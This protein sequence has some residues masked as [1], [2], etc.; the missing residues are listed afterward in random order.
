MEFESFASKMMKERQ[1]VFRAIFR[2]LD[3]GGRLAEMIY[4]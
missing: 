1:S 4:S 3:N 2:L